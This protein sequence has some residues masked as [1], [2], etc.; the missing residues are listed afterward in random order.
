MSLW[1]WIVFQHLSF[2]EGQARK[3]VVCQEEGNWRLN[4]SNGNIE[5]RLATI[6]IENRIYGRRCN[7]PL[8]GTDAG[9]DGVGV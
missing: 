3:E 9:S 1:W 4:M 5:E 8:T 6:L 2:V 7:C